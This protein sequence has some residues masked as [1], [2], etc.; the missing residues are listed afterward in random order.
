MNQL[1][2]SILLVDDQESIHDALGIGLEEAGY[3]VAHASNGET[4]FQMMLEGSFDAVITDRAMPRMTGEQLAQEIK[5][6]SPNTPVILI[7]GHLPNGSRVNLFDA[8]LHKPF[9]IT[10]LV[11]ALDRVLTHSKQNGDTL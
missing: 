2:H 8:V 3:F 10:E 11:G 9:S 1:Q 4:G 6:I 7:T 5:N